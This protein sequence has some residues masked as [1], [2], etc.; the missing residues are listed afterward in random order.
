MKKILR[1]LK[2]KW[3]SFK[4]HIYKKFLKPNYYI[5]MDVGIKEPTKFIVIA[6]EYDG[7]YQLVSLKNTDKR[8]TKQESIEILH[9]LM[10]RY[11]VTEDKVFSDLPYGYQREMFFN[12]YKRPQYFKP[13]LFE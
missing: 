7:E 2:G 4:L 3:Q 10:N 9:E 11:S 6:K 5:G 8:M 1:W 13:K 12:G